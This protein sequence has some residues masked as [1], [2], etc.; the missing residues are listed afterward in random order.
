MITYSGEEN[1]SSK[2][3]NQKVVIRAAM[4]VTMVMVLDD[5]SYLAFTSAI[6]IHL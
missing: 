6:R 4:E 5:L 2:P 3:G 1:E